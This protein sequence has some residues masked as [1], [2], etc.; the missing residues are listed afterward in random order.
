MK[1]GAK[2][3]RLRKL[4]GLTIEELADAADL[5]KG[6]ISQ[7][8]R[9]KTMPTVATLKQIMDVLGIDLATFFSGLEEQERNIFTRKERFEE[10]SNKG[11][12]VESLIPKLKYL[13]M[14]PVLLTL[15]PLAVY[16][17]N[18]EED[19]GFGFVVRG[20]VEITVG[21]ETRKLNRGDCFYLFFDNRLVIKNLTRRPAEILLVNY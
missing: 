20:R 8:E 7:I 6:L 15:T 18:Y 10:F 2:I 12:K 21:D 5:T 14:E 11:Y 9:D 1:I 4:K 3:R 19:E 13:E 16:E 17:K